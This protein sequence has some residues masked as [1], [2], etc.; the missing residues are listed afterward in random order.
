MTMPVQIIQTCGYEGLSIGKFV[1]RLVQQG[2]KTV[3]DVRAN[4]LSRKPGFSKKA[5]AASLA[6]AG[7]EYIHAP[8]LG[9]PKHVRD[10]YRADGDWAAYS[11]GFLS[12][13]AGQPEA[14]AEVVSI[15]MKGTAC[16][17]C[18]EADFNFCHRTFVARAAATLTKRRIVHL[19][20]REPVVENWRAAAA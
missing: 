15:A 14:I 16:L 13:L 2:T 10:R 6:A 4:P 11:R 17:V 19:T 7:I 1:D 12:Y 18:F 5:F 20:D 3:I 8:K 9:C